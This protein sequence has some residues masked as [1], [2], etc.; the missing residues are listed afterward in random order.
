MDVN[1]RNRAHIGK[2]T[3]TSACGKHKVGIGWVVRKVSKQ[4]SSKGYFKCCDFVYMVKDCPS[5]TDVNGVLKKEHLLKDC[6]KN[7][8]C[9]LTKEVKDPHCNCITDNT[10]RLASKIAAGI[11][12]K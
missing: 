3:A 9:L 7:S 12:R 1:N 6:S 10:S 5:T 2:Q 4:T 8:R 11:L